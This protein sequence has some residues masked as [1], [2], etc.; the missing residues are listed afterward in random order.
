[1]SKERE[2]Y[3]IS[4]RIDSRDVILDD[5]SYIK[6]YDERSLMDLGLAYAKKYAKKRTEYVYTSK[7]TGDLMRFSEKQSADHLELLC[8][9]V[10]YTLN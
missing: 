1:M 9:E 6:H 5:N 10:R 8:V 2:V 3:G 4:Y 7:R